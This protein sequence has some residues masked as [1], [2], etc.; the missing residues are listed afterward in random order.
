[1][2]LCPSDLQNDISLHIHTKVV[3]ENSSF[4]KLK[5]MALR[6]LARKFWTL[7]TAPGDKLVYQGEMLET[8]YFVVSG[9]LEVKDDKDIVRLLG[10]YI[11]VSIR[12]IVLSKQKSLYSA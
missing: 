1:M 7:N 12:K 10:K 8:L 2:E 9:A 11:I 5:K 3:N 6:Q 4:Y